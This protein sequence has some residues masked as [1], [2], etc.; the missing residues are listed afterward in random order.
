LKTKLNSLSDNFELIEFNKNN[1]KKF[2]K[3]LF[4][5]KKINTDFRINPT[6]KNAKKF[7][8]WITKKKIQSPNFFDAQRIHMIINKIISSSKNKKKIN[9]I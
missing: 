3:I 9:I 6:F 5:N 8:L 2:S 4:K 7:F 1:K